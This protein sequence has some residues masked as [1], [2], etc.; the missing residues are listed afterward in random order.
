MA[1]GS[2]PAEIW[3][4]V[5]LIASLTVLTCLGVLASQM[6]HARAVNKLR[7]E[8]HGLRRHYSKLFAGLPSHG[9][10]AAPTPAGEAEQ[11]SKAA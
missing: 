10:G 3:I 2:L 6:Q 8:V 7:T 4:V 11:T 1:D 9:R 5:G